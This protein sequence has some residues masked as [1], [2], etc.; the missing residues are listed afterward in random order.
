MKGV[1]VSCLADL[2]REKFGEDKWKQC[3]ERTGI[4]RHKTFFVSEDVN[5][6]TAVEILGSVCEVLNLSLAAAADAFGDYWV[7]EFAPRIYGGIYRGKKNA[8]EFLSAMDD[9]HMNMTSSLP[10][11]RPPRFEYSWESDNVMLMTYK[12]HRGLID[13]MIGLI[14]GVGNHF[15][16]DLEVSKISDTQVRIVFPSVQVS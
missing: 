7:N 11:A 10:N 5:D 12:S 15:G 13:V 1:I 3:L 14:K 6:E 9:V 4:D 2:V 16:E 8:R